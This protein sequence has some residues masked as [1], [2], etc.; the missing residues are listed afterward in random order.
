[1]NFTGGR[2]Y[3]GGSGRTREA[4]FAAGFAWGFSAE[5]GGATDSAGFSTAFAGALR[6]G[7]W[8]GG[9]GIVAGFSIGFTKAGFSTGGGKGVTGGAAG[10]FAGVAAGG[11]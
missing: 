4:D 8:L 5:G 7:F 3:T 2:N 10:G 6:R 1:M 9:G 11:K